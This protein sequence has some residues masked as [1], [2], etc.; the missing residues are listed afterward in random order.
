MLTR[1]AFLFGA[2]VAVTAPRLLTHIETSIR[3]TGLP[4]LLTPARPSLVLSC[5]EEMECQLFIGTGDPNKAPPIPTWREYLIDQGEIRE[6]FH[7]LDAGLREQVLEDRGICEEDLDTV[8]CWD[9]YIGQWARRQGP[10]AEAYRYL[11]DLD[12]GPLDPDGRQP[13]ALNFF[14]GYSP[15]NDGLGV[16]AT[17]YE[18][19]ALLQ[20]RLD[21]LGTGAAVQLVRDGRPVAGFGLTR[22]GLAHA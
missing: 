16:H 3:T 1:R 9:T 2:A 5:H 14:D 11:E 19:L 6:D 4:P 20:H 12:L 21:E 10:G 13:H 8:M 17:S 22:G 18:A 7:L 15:G